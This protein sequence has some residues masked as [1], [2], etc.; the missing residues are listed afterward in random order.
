MR[1]L[2]L[3]TGNLLNKIMKG[4]EV[5]NDNDLTVLAMQ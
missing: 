1:Y 4:V 3:I 5:Q 2:I